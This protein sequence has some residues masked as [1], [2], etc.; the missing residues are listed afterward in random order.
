MCHLLLAVLHCGLSHWGFP[1]T[2]LVCLSSLG[3]LVSITAFS[4]WCLLG[5]LSE[6]T[7]GSPVWHKS[8]LPA[9]VACSSPWCMC[10]PWCAPAPERGLWNYMMYCFCVP[11]CKWGLK[12]NMQTPEMFFPQ[13]N[14]EVSSWHGGKVREEGHKTN[15]V[16]LVFCYWRKIEKCGR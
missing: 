5:A 7:C 8:V 14:Y 1:G 12:E 10:T 6:P 3:F 11:K 15:P 2:A 16:V 13:K 4:L 9:G